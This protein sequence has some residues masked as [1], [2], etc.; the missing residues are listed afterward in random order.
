MTQYISVEIVQGVEES[1]NKSFSVT[2]PTSL[3]NTQ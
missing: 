2:R 3:E 1:N